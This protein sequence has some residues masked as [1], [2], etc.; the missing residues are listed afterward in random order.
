[1]FL[2]C[3]VSTP[4]INSRSVE[5]TLLSTHRVSE[6]EGGQIAGGEHATCAER[7]QR[8]DVVHRLLLGHRRRRRRRGVL[9]AAE[10]G[11]QLQLRWALLHPSLGR[12]RRAPLSLSLSLSRRFWLLLRPRRRP[13]STR[14]LETGDA[15][16]QSTE[17]D[18]KKGL[19]GDRKRKET[20]RGKEGGK[21]AGSQRSP[22]WKA[23][24]CIFRDCFLQISTSLPLRGGRRPSRRRTAAVRS[25]LDGYIGER[26]ARA[27][28]VAVCPC[29]GLGVQS[30]RE[31]VICVSIRNCLGAH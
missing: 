31:I 6:A 29:Y 30:E 26:R 12:Q 14:L 10:E 4:L 2:L 11:L 15:A 20:R 7:R 28:A 16:K 13:Q 21:V 8:S 18:E 19:F 22:A 24:C 27:A 25:V 3:Y 9:P 23:D 1:M 17:G 5:V